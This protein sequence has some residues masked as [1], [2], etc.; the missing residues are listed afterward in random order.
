MKN[1]NRSQTGQH[2]IASSDATQ[3]QGQML[4]WKELRRK[5]ESIDD[6]KTESLR[7]SGRDQKPER[8]KE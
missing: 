3:C 6:C 7:S 4:A 5:L 2:G 1:G 8:A